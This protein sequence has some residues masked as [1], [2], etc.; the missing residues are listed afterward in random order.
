MEA[1]PVI[2]RFKDEYGFL[3]NFKS[4]EVVYPKGQEGEMRYP[5]VE[6]AYQAAKTLDQKQREW[7]RDAPTAAEAK[8]RG[9]RVTM[10]PTWNTRSRL[11]VMEGL[12]RQ[13]FSQEPFR[14]Q[15]LA[16]GNA[17]L[18]EG[19]YHHDQFWGDCRCEQHIGMGGLN[20]LGGLLTK[21]RAGLQADA[22]A[23]HQEGSEDRR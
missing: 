11:T 18:I 1:V 21:I 10:R 8:G 7:I 17:E 19:N 5:S 20:W 23:L 12:L 14:S 4:V 3:S 6:H 22:E 2:D 15:L 13:K 9:Y 16:T